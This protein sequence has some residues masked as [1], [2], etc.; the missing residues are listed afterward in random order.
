MSAATSH[1]GSASE[2]RAEGAV[3]LVGL[4]GAMGAGKTTALE[5]LAE[6]GAQTLSTDRVVHELY[7]CDRLRDLL[8]ERWGAEI[9]PGGVVNRDAVAARIFSD[10]QERSWLERTIWPLVGER[11]AVWYA[12]SR[13]QL[14][15]PRAAIVETPLLFESGM[16]KA[17]DATIAVLATPEHLAERTGERSHV[18]KSARE[19]RQ[20]PAEEKA[21]Q[22]TYVVRNDGSL[23]E[24]RAELARVLDRLQGE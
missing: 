17:C 2:H 5:I 18:A 1:A 11:I 4:T 10:Q 14:P 15:P 8:V 22:A 12:L 7:N 6:L 21:R 20:L 13:E 16:D 19:R 3:P 24:L 9:A 23:A